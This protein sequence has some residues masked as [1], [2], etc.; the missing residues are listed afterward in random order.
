MGQLLIPIL[1]IYIYNGYNIICSIYVDSITL[2]KNIIIISEFQN[3]ERASYELKVELKLK[4][5]QDFIY[6][7]LFFKFSKALALG[8]Y[9]KP[10][11]VEFMNNYYLT[12]SR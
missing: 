11:K 1:K 3:K 2:M 10:M 6:I 8:K 4:V 7:L 5:M 12:C 9:L